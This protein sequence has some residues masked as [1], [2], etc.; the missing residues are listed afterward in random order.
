MPVG[1][2]IALRDV[3]GEAQHVLVVGVVPPQ[4]DLDADA[5]RTA[6]LLAAH[7]HHRLLEQRRLG[8]VEIAHESL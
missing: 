8:A 7:H 5:A 3:V 2:A 6:V 4:R 1:A